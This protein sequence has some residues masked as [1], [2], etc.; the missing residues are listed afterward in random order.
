MFQVTNKEYVYTQEQKLEYFLL[1]FGQI[2][3]SA[4]SSCSSKSQSKLQPIHKNY[5]I[6]YH[7]GDT[8]YNSQ[9]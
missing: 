6:Q 9:T 1:F 4:I 3:S 7:T 2:S 8:Q 5:L